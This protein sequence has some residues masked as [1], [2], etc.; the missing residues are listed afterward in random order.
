MRAQRRI[1]A[2]GFR[3]CHGER[4]LMGLEWSGMWPEATMKPLVISE[5][6]DGG[7]GQGTEGK[8]DMEIHGGPSFHTVG[9]E[10]NRF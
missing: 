1:E 4:A 10:I 5:Q 3:R 7:A 6:N 8:L 9:K 2:V